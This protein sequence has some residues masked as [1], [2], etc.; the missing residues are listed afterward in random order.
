VPRILAGGVALIVVCGV[1]LAVSALTSHSHKDRTTAAAANTLQPGYRQ[2]L[3]PGVFLS[4]SPIPTPSPSKSRKPKVVASPKPSAPPRK[5]VKVKAAS[6][7][8][9]S[10]GGPPWTTRVLHAPYVLRSGRT[11]RTNR[12][13][14]TM[15]TDGNLVLRDKRGNPIWATGTNRPGAHAI[16]QNDGNLVIYS[17][18]NRPVWGAGCQG[19]DHPTMVLQADANLVIRDKNGKPT[20]A[21]DTWR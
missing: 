2:Q 10:A 9:P 8:L 20:W 5:H 1:V 13:A 17:T 16:L 18:G 11:V 12:I 6:N 15:Q 14:L 19:H 7:A 3:P 21:S 4:T